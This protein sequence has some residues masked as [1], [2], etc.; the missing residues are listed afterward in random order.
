LLGPPAAFTAS[1]SALI[2]ASVPNAGCGTRGQWKWP[3]PPRCVDESLSELPAELANRRVSFVRGNPARDETLKRAS[4]STANHAVILVKRPGDPHSDDHNLAVTLAVEG[5]TP[6][7]RTV[8]ECVELESEELLRKAG[9]DSIVCIARFESHFITT[10][11]ISPGVQDLVDDL[12]SSLGGQQVYFTGW[13]GGAAKFE[14]VATRCRKEGHIAIG[15]RRQKR[16]QINVEGG[17]EVHAGDD[18]IT[19]GPGQLRDLA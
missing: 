17:F 2:V 5:H 12:M 16:V 19:I 10:E 6:R 4:I 3:G 7:V 11:T 14:A 18:V 8:V 1:R 15:V 9:A 13:G